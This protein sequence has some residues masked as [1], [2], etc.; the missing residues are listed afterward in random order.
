[1]IFQQR[2]IG[3]SAILMTIAVMLS[4]CGTAPAD[5]KRLATIRS[6]FVEQIPEPQYRVLVGL[7]GMD[8][9]PP[10]SNP[11]FNDMMLKQGFR[12]GAETHDALASALAKDGYQIVADK[13]LADAVLKVA[14]MIGGYG[15]EPPIAGGG[16]APIF[17]VDASMEN[18]LDGA[19]LLRHRYSFQSSGGAGLTGHIVLRADAKYFAE[20]C[21]T[22]WSNPQLPKEAFRAMSAQLTQSIAIELAKTPIAR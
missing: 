6:V 13:N 14:F 9:S 1:M 10:G 8:M 15:A 11:S 16:C 20:D 3:R 2:L 12:L 18:A 21:D 17:F 7:G 19:T 22:L 4:S 5:L